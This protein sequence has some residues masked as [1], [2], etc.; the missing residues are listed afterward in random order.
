MRVHWVIYNGMRGSRWWITCI[1]E[2]SNRA[3]EGWEHRVIEPTK[4]RAN[5]YTRR[6]RQPRHDEQSRQYRQ[7]ISKCLS[8]WLCSSLSSRSHPSWSSLPSTR[9][10]ASGKVATAMARP[11]SLHLH[12]S[13]W[14]LH[15]CY[16]NRSRRNGPNVV[17]RAR[18][19]R[20]PHGGC[21]SSWCSRC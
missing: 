7:T 18:P 4:T 14:A 11:T 19:A 6:T 12:R 9:A 13:F 15:R 8:A 1:K 10:A 21:A 20:M 2:R 16:Q 5:N 17:G 3:M